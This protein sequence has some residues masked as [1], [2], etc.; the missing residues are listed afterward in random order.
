MHSLLDMSIFYFVRA[1]HLKDKLGRQGDPDH[2][3]ERIVGEYLSL[4]DSAND[5][6]AAVK[7]QMPGNNEYSFDATEVYHRENVVFLREASRLGDQWAGSL[8]KVEYW[9]ND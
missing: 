5:A 7:K 8:P 6:I 1:F 9:W 3:E 2:S 4:A